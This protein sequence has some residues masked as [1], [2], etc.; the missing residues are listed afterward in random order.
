M[1]DTKIISLNEIES[2]YNCCDNPHVIEHNSEKVCENCGMVFESSTV[3]SYP[4]LIYEKK[5]R[6]TNHC[7]G[8]NGVFGNRTDFQYRYDYTRKIIS[9][10]NQ[11]LMKRL[12]HLQHNYGNSSERSLKKVEPLLK[13]IRSHF[14]FP[15]YMLSEI[16]NIVIKIIDNISIQGYSVSSVVYAVV[17]YYWK[18]NSF[19]YTLKSLGKQFNVDLN[20]V[21]NY[22]NRFKSIIISQLKA[23]K[24]PIMNNI[25]STNVAKPMLIDDRI[26][27]KQIR[28]LVQQKRITEVINFCNK[29][30]SEFKIPTE[31]TNKIINSSR[32]IICN[33]PCRSRQSNT[34]A[35][36]LIYSISNKAKYRITQSKLSKNANICEVTLRDTVKEIEPYLVI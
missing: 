15:E 25:E 36:A 27:I 3:V 21:K 2:E 35:V 28:Q 11:Q 13:D 30:C 26:K 20:K 12:Y 29:Y 31:I 5:E 22:L 23:I 4:E 7:L 17:F 9:V 10:K 33:N 16:Y 18:I 8:R 19:P 6:I 24:T 14:T 32:T 34:I 1:I